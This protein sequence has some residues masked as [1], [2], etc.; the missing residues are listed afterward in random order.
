MTGIRLTK[1]STWRLPNEVLNK[2]SKKY[3]LPCVFNAVQY[4]L[5]D[6]GQIAVQFC[7][8]FANIGPSLAKNIPISQ[9]CCR[10]FCTGNFCEFVQFFAFR[11]SFAF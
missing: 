3:N 9:K 7:K 11:D 1:E 4:E 6:P 5:P 8:Y 10:F 2:K